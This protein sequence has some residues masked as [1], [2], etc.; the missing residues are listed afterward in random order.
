VVT[1]QAGRAGQAGQAGRAGKNIVTLSN[2]HDA[3]VSCERCPRLRSYCAEVA[4]VKK[5]AYR[6]ET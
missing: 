3:I 2:V 5:R 1:G 4:R 6:D